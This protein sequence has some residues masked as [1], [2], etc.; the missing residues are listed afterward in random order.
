MARVISAGKR[1]LVLARPFLNAAGTLG[2]AEELSRWI[3]LDALGAFVTHPVSRRPRTSAGGP[4][5]A[6]FAGG[7]MLHTGLPNPGLRAVVRA[8]RRRW[9]RMPVPVIVHLIPQTAEEAADLVRALEALDSVAAVQLGL[10]E[11]E[12]GA[13]LELIQAAARGEL[14]LIVQLP[15]GVEP[16]LAQEAAAAGANA[17]SLGPA[18]GAF[19]REDGDAQSA[20][21]YGP[22]LYP[23]ALESV[24]RLAGNLACPLIAGSGVYTRAAAE[25]LLAA[26]AVAV[27]L[28]AVLWTEPEAI[29]EGFLSFPEA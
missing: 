14:P 15:V 5:F 18:R 4:R 19:P 22:A 2:Y 24:R 10:P 6:P 1:E 26:G 9:A 23:Q 20:R 16:G 28:D 7:F 17:I 8:N 11:S 13:G 29:E 25:A 27:T 12:P 3:R 21:L